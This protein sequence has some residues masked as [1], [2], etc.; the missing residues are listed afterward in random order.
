MRELYNLYRFV[1]ERI[2]GRYLFT[3]TYFWA[4]QFF[5]KVVLRRAASHRIL[6]DTTVFIT[7]RKTRVAGA[8]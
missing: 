1:S 8:V 2:R 6:P 3:K 7:I 4:R 5:E